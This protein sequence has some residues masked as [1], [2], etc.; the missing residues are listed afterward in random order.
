MPATTCPKCKVSIKYLD[1]LIGA[2]QCPVCGEIVLQGRAA[3]S[4]RE[5][6]PEVAEPLVPILHDEDEPASSRRDEKPLVPPTPGVQGA[7]T[8]WFGCGLL[9]L[10]INAVGY[11][12]IWGFVLYVIVA[13]GTL[14]PWQP[15]VTQVVLMLGTFAYYVFL[16]VAGARLQSGRWRALLAPA[17]C[18]AAVSMPLLVLNGTLLV[19]FVAALTDGAGPRP[20]GLALDNWLLVVLLLWCAPFLIVHLVLVGASARLA[21]ES[22]QALQVREPDPA[23]QPVGVRAAGVSWFITGVLGL[24]VNYAAFVFIWAFLVLAALTTGIVLSSA[25]I[26]LLAL[27]T[28][29]TLG[30]YVGLATIGTGLRAGTWRYLQVPA[31]I[32]LGMGLVLFLFNAGFSASIIGALASTPA[33]GEARLNP[34]SAGLLLAW[35]VPFLVVDI[36]LVSSSLRLLWQSARQ[37]HW[38]NSHNAKPKLAPLPERTAFPGAITLAGSL[39]L[40]LGLLGV[41]GNLYFAVSYIQAND[42]THTAFARGTVLLGHALGAVVAVLTAVYLGVL[43]LGARLPSTTPAGIGFLILTLLSLVFQVWLYVQFDEFL[44]L[45]GAT[46]PSDVVGLLRTALL[47]QF[48][49][50]GLACVASLACIVGNDGYRSWLRTWRGWQV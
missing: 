48:G 9:G 3:P 39:W 36:V 7:G 37:A 40:L 32:A 2:L 12:V 49:V 10:C 35:V 15:M 50:L 23:S 47:V 34:W 29:G 5:D 4:R 22:G 18:V 8:A 27:V 13:S 43:L 45:S 31:G 44:A 20:I 30:F 16:M 21:W 38:L 28:V 33:P 6:A 19:S 11:L 1:D 24:L 41:A 17:T 46:L 14:P 42:P 25:A 26:G